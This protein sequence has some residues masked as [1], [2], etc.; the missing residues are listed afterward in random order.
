MKT[1]D[2]NKVDHKKLSDHVAGRLAH[3]ILKYQALFTRILSVRTN[4][5]SLKQQ[6]IFLCLICIIFGGG[7]ILAMVGSFKVITNNTVVIPATNSIIV[8][9]LPNETSAKITLEEL[10]AA[11]QFKAAHPDLQDEIPDLYERLNL[12]IETY[13]SQKIK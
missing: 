9:S 13:Y 7:S 4:Q 1:A 6:W 2:N 11:K 12:I 5:W 3:W 10:E 8:K